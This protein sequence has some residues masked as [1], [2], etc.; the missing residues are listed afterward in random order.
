[1]RKTLLLAIVCIGQSVLAGG[2]PH[3]P[4]KPAVQCSDRS[5]L[6]D[7]GNG[8]YLNQ[9]NKQP[10]FVNYG[11]ITKDANGTYLFAFTSAT[12]STSDLS[13]GARGTLHK[14]TGEN[15]DCVQTVDL[16]IAF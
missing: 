16:P 1:M 4:K 9:E 7:G 8:Y 10:E 2:G 12:Y 3:E 14:H 15:I 6:M 11:G 5:N 13:E